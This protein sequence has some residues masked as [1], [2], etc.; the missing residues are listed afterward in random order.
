MDIF[1][2]I[3][4]VVAFLLVFYEGAMRF[5]V[6]HPVVL[7]H[8]PR[9]I[10]N[11]I[12]HIHVTAERRIMQ[13]LPEAGR[14]DDELGYT[15][16]PGEFVFSCREFSN[17]YRIN[18]L[19]VRDGEEALQS[20]EIIVAGDS[21]SVGWGVN[22]EETFAKFLERK[23][24]LRVLNMAVPSYGTAREMMMLRR[25]P[26]DHL[27][28]LI[29]QYCADDH[30]ENRRFFQGGN[31]LRVM[32]AETFRRLTE[33]HSRPQRY[34][35]GKYLLLKIRKRLDEAS[36]MKAAPAVAEPDEAELFINALL[37]NESILSNVRLILF[38]MNGKN[39]TNTLTRAVAG[40]ILSGDYPGFLKE[41]LILDMS[42]HL[43]EEHFYVLDD[44]LTR[45]GQEVVADVLFGAIRE[46]ESHG[47]H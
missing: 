32:R 36:Q 41:M 12:G 11:T 45:E 22:Q 30:D 31:H 4:V 19:G 16:R 35:P 29:I 25:V 9:R 21:F 20:P 1:W 37:W 5:L 3:L 18:R 43:R 38:E 42:E 26:T 27:K 24:G 2:I 47:I 39:Q 14:H 33:I 8:C 7:K 46:K 34:F 10:I 13:Y 23:T 17:L 15:L 28:Y 44:H 6:T 40:K